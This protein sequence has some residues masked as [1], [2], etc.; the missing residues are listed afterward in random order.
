MGNAF[1]AV[2]RL[3]R[4]IDPGNL[5]FLHID[6]FFDC[7]RGEKRLAPFHVRRKFCEAI[8][9]G[10]VYSNGK[11]CAVVHIEFTRI[12]ICIQN[13]IITKSFK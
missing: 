13:N 4:F 7:L 6:K 1:T 3:K 11:D 10:L 5:P 8:F 2:E 12:V 9:Y